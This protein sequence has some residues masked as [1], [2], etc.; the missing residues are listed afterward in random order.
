MKNQDRFQWVILNEV[1]EAGRKLEWNYFI[2]LGL[3]PANKARSLDML[4][5][6][7]GRDNGLVNNQFV[8]EVCLLLLGYFMDNGHRYSSDWLQK[9][10]YNLKG[11]TIH[12]QKGYLFQVIPRIPQKNKNKC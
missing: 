5:V 4:F 11:L 10:I 8:Y 6:C 2:N 9:K 3:G 12:N 1:F 7:E